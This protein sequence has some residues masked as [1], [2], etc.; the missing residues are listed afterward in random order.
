MHIFEVIQVI[1]YYLHD[2][3]FIKI[4]LLLPVLAYHC[5]IYRNKQLRAHLVAEA[6]DA[7]LDNQLLC[8]DK[9]RIQQPEQHTCVS[10][11]SDLCL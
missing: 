11:H 5:F 8:H 7:P 9:E 2:K 4:L 6:S 1:E 3:L 10:T